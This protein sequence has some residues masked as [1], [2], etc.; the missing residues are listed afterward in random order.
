MKK[1][2]LV[3]HYTEDGKTFG[4]K[5]GTAK[6]DNMQISATPGRFTRTKDPN[7]RIHMDFQ[8]GARGN[9]TGGCLNVHGRKALEE[10]RAAINAA[11]ED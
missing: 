2:T 3:M 4:G 10:I 9:F 5:F 7:I 11:L 6:D 1:T 8:R